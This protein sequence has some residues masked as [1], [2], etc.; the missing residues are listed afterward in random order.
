MASW[1][2]RTDH[3]TS[4]CY[5]ALVVG[6]GLPMTQAHIKAG[7]KAKLVIKCSFARSRGRGELWIGSPNAW[8]GREA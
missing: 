2:H 5:S 8:P 3:T 7:T 4:P 1:K 6:F